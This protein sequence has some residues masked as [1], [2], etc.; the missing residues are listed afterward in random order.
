MSVYLCVHVL[1][2]LLRLSDV[3]LQRVTNNHVS[4]YTGIDSCVFVTCAADCQVQS[5]SGYINYLRLP[6]CTLKGRDDGAGV[7][8]LVCWLLVLF[9]ALGT[10]AEDFFC[11]SL[12]VISDTLGLSDNVVS[13]GGV[14]AQ[15]KKWKLRVR[16]PCVCA[17]I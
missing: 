8:V 3:H 16:P 12:S 7:V 6:F 15:K 9:V 2:R 11:P 4:V 1:R 13:R 10:T 17:D 14:V 5:D